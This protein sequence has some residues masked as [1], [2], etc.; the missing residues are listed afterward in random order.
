M[1]TND[2]NLIRWILPVTL[3][4][5]GACGCASTGVGSPPRGKVHEIN[6]VYYDSLRYRR[7]AREA[8]EAGASPGGI[9]FRT[10]G[11]ADLQTLDC[12]TPGVLLE[13][14]RPGN[15]PGLDPERVR[16][17][18]DSIESPIEVHWRLKREAQPF[19]ELI[20]EEGKPEEGGTPACLKELFSIIPI[21]REIVFEG[22]SR[23]GVRSCFSSRPNWDE[24]RW[25]GFKIS[26]L[27]KRDLKV[28]F[29]FDF[30]GLGD[31]PA[32]R[33]EAL[34]ASWMMA[35]FLAEDDDGKRFLPSAVMADALCRK[36]IGSADLDRLRDP[37]RPPG[38]AWS[39][40]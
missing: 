8:A 20:V 3:A 25:M 40:R 14:D 39:V 4:C 27:S 2:I 5:L 28:E 23:E 36:C 26:F 22:I 33:V 29:P 34:M 12:V 11:R 35:P 1:N 7:P 18:V 30:E 15:A 9:E 24:D 21:P 19:W 31:T 37:K 38:R 32:G 16:A 13:K 6:T 17:C 10:V